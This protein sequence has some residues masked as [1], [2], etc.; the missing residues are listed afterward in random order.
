MFSL[1]KRKIDRQLKQFR[2]AISRK[3]IQE[4][5]I[6]GFS[7]IVLFEMK[8]TID[9]QA[10]LFYSFF[11]FRISLLFISLSADINKK[12]IELL[13]KQ[14]FNKSCFADITFKR[15]TSNVA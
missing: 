13:F 10:I 3:V 6:L 2:I 12:K 7:F 4:E 11:L 1:N 15:C 14:F 5:G 8:C 9:E